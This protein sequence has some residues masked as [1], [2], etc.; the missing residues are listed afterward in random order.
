MTAAA[1]TKVSGRVNGKMIGLP[2]MIPMSLA[3]A[4]SD[5]VNVTEPITTSSTTKTVVETEGVCMVVRTMKSWSATSAAAPP[6]TALK[7]ETSWG[8][9]VIGTVRPVMRPAVAPMAKPTMM[10]A[11][12]VPLR[13]PSRAM[14]LPSV[15]TTATTMPP[16]DSRL[17]LR[18]VAGEFMNRSP[19]T[20]QTAPPSWAR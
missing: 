15:A 9:A 4:R 8:I 13:P 10:M 16:A 18:A 1:T 19:R 11:Q 20:K 14:R 2:L 6:P 3:E 12:A 5:P 7:I 17:P